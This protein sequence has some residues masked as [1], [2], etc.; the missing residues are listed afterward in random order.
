MACV[1]L[2]CCVGETMAAMLIIVS[3]QYNM[4]SMIRVM[5]RRHKAGESASRAIFNFSSLFI[6]VRVIEVRFQYS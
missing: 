4:E 3:M 2:Q 1:L 6:I 5:R